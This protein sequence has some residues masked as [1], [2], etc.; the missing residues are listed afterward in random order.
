MV[1]WREVGELLEAAIAEMVERELGPLGVVGDDVANAGKAF[2]EGVD[3]DDGDLSLA[4]LIDL[5]TIAEANDHAV[6]VPEIGE[7][8]ALVVIL[9]IEQEIPVAVVLRVVGDAADD[10]AAPA[11]IG[12]DEDGDLASLR[13]G[14]HGGVYCEMRK[15]ESTKRGV[16]GVRWQVLRPLAFI[17]F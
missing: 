9:R 10:A 8:G 3:V 13:A 17:S 1:G 16:N 7:R 14:I 2:E 11:I 4:N 15:V 6:A 5:Q 12:F